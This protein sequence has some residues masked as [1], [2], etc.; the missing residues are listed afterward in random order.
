[1]GSEMCI[2]DRCSLSL[3]P[4]KREAKDHCE[5]TTVVGYSQPARPISRCDR[6]ALFRDESN[7][8]ATRAMQ[9]H[10][11]RIQGR[12]SRALLEGARQGT[13]HVSARYA[14]SSRYN[15]SFGRWR[16]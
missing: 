4:S 12:D 13:D 9:G 6:H 7:A 11:A 14:P 16:Q 3:N 1:M 8:A 10:S 5:D 2:R 15:G